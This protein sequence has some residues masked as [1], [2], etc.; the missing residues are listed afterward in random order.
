M[1]FAENLKGLRHQHGMTQADV[2][3]ELHVSRKTISSWENGRTYPDLATLVT[4]SDV[5][6]VSLDTLLKKD[7]SMVQH[8]QQQGRT[9]H[10]NARISRVTG[11]LNCGLLF[12]YYLCGL[13]RWSVGAPILGLLLIN[14]L[15]LS[16]TYPAYQTWWRPAWHLV[17]VS[18]MAI[19]L[20][21]ALLGTLG[22]L[23]P[24]NLVGP[25]QA[26]AESGAAFGSVLAFIVK[27][28]LLTG[29]SLFVF[30]GQNGEAVIRRT[31][32]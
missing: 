10:R 31:T 11:Y 22:G 32:K 9:S 19:V 29:S 21:G 20:N 28:V 3:A 2:A 17:V 13:L 25:Y 12:L 4:V 16:V 26:A 7:V 30:F 24:D 23:T 14:L 1:D 27:D 18:F 5:Y 8:Y 6:Q 15:L